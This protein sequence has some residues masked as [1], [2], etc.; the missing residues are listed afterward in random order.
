MQRLRFEHPEVKASWCHRR[1][2]QGVLR[3][4]QHPDARRVDARPQGQLLQVHQRDPQRH[5][6]RVGQLRVRCGSRPSTAPPPAAATSWPWR[7]TRSCSSTTASSAVSLP[8]VPLLA[9]LPGT[10]G[11]TRVVDKRY[12][13]RDLADVFATRTEG[14]KGQQAVDWGLVDAI[15]PKSGFD[16]LVAARALAR[17]AE[18][19]PAGRRRGHR[20]ADPRQL[21]RSDRRR[22]C[23][24]RTSTSTSTAISAAHDSPF[25]HPQRR[26]PATGDELVAAGAE[27]WLLLRRSSSTTRSCICASTNRDRHVG[28]DDRRQHRRGV[29]GGGRCSPAMPTT[30]SCARSAC[31]GRAR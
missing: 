21:D 13:R 2:R 30:G 4:R 12:V 3:R 17:A 6:G 10:G 7:A 1:R 14:V 28:S 24:R 15:A 18:L 16:E 23:G 8:E 25:A 29:P 11:L 5:R 22:R 9:V 20:A 26:Q 31:C 27:A 19:R